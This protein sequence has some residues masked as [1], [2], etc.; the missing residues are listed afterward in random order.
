MLFLL[1]PY[2][3]KPVDSQ[4]I[5]NLLNKND[6]IEIGGSY[7]EDQAPLP[8]YFFSGSNM[9]DYEPSPDKVDTTEVEEDSSSLPFNC[10]LSLYALLQ[11]SIS[12]IGSATL[13]NSSGSIFVPPSGQL[14][15]ISGPTIAEEFRLGDSP[16]PGG[17]IVLEACIRGIVV[18]KD[19]KFRWSQLSIGDDQFD[20]PLAMDI[21]NHLESKSKPTSSPEPGSIPSSAAPDQRS[22]NEVREA[23][24]PEVTTPAMEQGLVLGSPPGQEAIHRVANHGG[25]NVDDIIAYL[26]HKLHIMVDDSFFMPVSPTG[27]TNRSYQDN[28]TVETVAASFLELGPD[29]ELG[30]GDETG[31]TTFDFGVSASPGSG[32]CLNG[33]GMSSSGNLFIGPPIIG[34]GSQRGTGSTTDR[35]GNASS[36]SSIL[37]RLKFDKALPAELEIRVEEKDVVGK[38]EFG[39]VLEPHAGGD[40]EDTQT[41]YEKLTDEVSNL[42]R[43]ISQVVKKLW[44][45]ACCWKALNG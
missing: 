41:S 39:A 22:G 40:V 4:H 45:R 32:A 27:G 13:N 38:P 28:S 3:P 23:V 5:P 14:G 37:G 6:L 31:L 2:I 9:L 1:A 29:V 33:F 25:V 10:S 24:E 7:P 11:A 16:I 34:T 17:G 35:S 42:I 8:N 43:K 30:E 19:L 26:S 15:L 21:I 18:R 12:D 36:S 44:S 20:D